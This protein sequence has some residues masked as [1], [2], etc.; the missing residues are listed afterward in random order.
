V[1]ER[2]GGLG[3]SAFELKETLESAPEVCA[4]CRFVAS[5]LR[6]QIDILFYENVNDMQTRDRIRRAGGV[7]RHHAALVAEQSDALGTA[8]IMQDLLNNEWSALEAGKFDHP[9][10]PSGRFGRLLDSGRQPAKR[11][12]C[13]LCQA[14]H[15]LDQRTVDSLLEALDNAEFATAFAGCAGL[16]VP[17]FHLAFERC[18]HEA[19][20]RVV[21]TRQREALHQLAEELGE[22]ARTYDYRSRVKPTADEAR[23]WRRGLSVSSGWLEK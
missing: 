12:L 4:V 10:G 14:E 22:L 13:P 15:E 23:A 20:W 9:G 5:A 19:Q 8:I 2:S 18:K 11:I 6:R 3:R 1:R 17:H 16:C 7:C 21:L